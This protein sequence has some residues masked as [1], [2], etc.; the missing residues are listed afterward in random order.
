MLIALLRLENTFFVPT[1]SES[2]PR[3]RL[4]KRCAAPIAV[5]IVFAMLAV[6]NETVWELGP[7]WCAR[8]MLVK[9]MLHME[10]GSCS[11][12][13]IEPPITG[14]QPSSQASAPF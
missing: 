5:I 4:L 12:A 10:D 8:Y 14:V 7:E 2:A 13:A 6:A 11:S 9:Y 1:K 3:W